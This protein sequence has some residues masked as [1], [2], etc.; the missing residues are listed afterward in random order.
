MSG[1]HRKAVSSRS[2]L[3]D[4]ARVAGVSLATA[5]RAINRPE[6]VSDEIRERVIR[7]TRILSYSPHRGARSLGSGRSFAIGAVIPTL[8]ISV[9]AMGIETIQE[10]LGENGYTLLLAT[11][12]YDRLKEAQHMRALVGQG[13]DGLILVGDMFDPDAISL[14]RAQGIP[15]ISTYVCESSNALPTIG[16]DNAQGSEQIVQHLLD[17]G[18]REFGIITNSRLANDRA[19]ARRDGALQALSHQGIHL[20]PDRIIDVGFP[21]IGEGRLGLG[22]LLASNPLIT[23]VICTA[24]GL[25]IGALMEAAHLGLKVP[26]DLSISG[27]DDM[28][29]AAFTEPQLTTIHVPAREIGE[30][31]AQAMLSAIEEKQAPASTKLQAQLIVRES[32]GPVRPTLRRGAANR[33]AA[34]T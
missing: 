34:A 6:I 14:V 16:I 23:A 2:K 9:I 33:Y 22:R 30:L 29:F 7:A 27:Y 28:D 4:V 24:D 18:H 20:G 10:R 12:Q 15:T 3:E 8:Q 5:S 17:L 31:T 19:I 25:A 1:R 32:T 13:V 11:S 21:A 26:L